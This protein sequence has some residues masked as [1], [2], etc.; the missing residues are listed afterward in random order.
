MAE[1]KNIRAS[2]FRETQRIVQ[3][4]SDL[5]HPEC[6]LAYRTLARWMTLVIVAIWLLFSESVSSDGIAPAPRLPV[7]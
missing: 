3:R 7:K 1:N 5:V 4:Q 2:S 6:C